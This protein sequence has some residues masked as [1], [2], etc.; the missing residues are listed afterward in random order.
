MLFVNFLTLAA[1]H[2]SMVLV[3]LKPSFLTNLG[4]SSTQPQISESVGLQVRHSRMAESV[5]SQAKSSNET[6]EK[7]SYK[8]HGRSHGRF[9]LYSFL[10]K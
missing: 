9:V 10:I 6:T 2:I 5:W 8:S 1:A 7:S 4:W 3:G